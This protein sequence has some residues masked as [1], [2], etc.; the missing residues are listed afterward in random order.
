MTLQQELVF[1]PLGGVGEI[2]MNLSIY[3]IG[4][5][6]DRTWLAVDLGVS[7]AA[8][9]HLPGID[10]ILPDIRYLIEERRN[11]A[12]L[13][14]THAHEDH[15]GALLELWPRLKVPLYATPFTAALL[16]AKRLG[17]PGAPEIPVKIIPVGGRFT[18]G[19]FDIEFVTMAHSIPESNAL[20]IRTSGGTIL[21]TGDWKIDPTPILRDPT[22]E[23]KLRALGQ[24]GCLALVGDSTN[25]VREGRSP[26][27]TDVA[28]T[29]AELVKTAR[30][31]VAVTTFASNVARLRAVADAARAAEREVVVIGRAMERIVQIARETG[32][33]EGVQDFHPVEAYGYLP[34]NKVVA[35]CTGS[36]GESRAALSRIAE[37]QH[38]EVT[39]SRGDRVIYSARTIPGNEKAVGRV[40]NLLIEQGIEVITDRTHLV[41]VSGHP[42]RAELEEMF[43][44]VKPKIVIP[45]HG[46][47]LHLHEHAALARR[48]GVPEVVQCRNGDLVQLAPQVRI[49]DEV[50]AGRLYKDG[51]LLVEAEA[52][53]VADRRRLGFAGAVSVALAI[54]D[55][56]E[57]IDEPSLD[58]IGIPERDRDGG[59]IHEAVRNTV[60][61]TL[62]SLPRGRRRDPDAVAEAVRRAVRATI[63]QRWGKKPMCHV[64]VLEV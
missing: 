37:D 2:G 14:L 40:I 38:P 12:G 9:E 62:E 61:E 18:V 4:H 58:L 10:L 45:V 8:E 36:Q 39:F 46:E 56:G 35:L 41:H 25:A 5:E 48:C 60:I 6:H 43:G 21:H 55:R 7:F 50:P 57:L 64:H 27:E 22:D 34:P 1:A 24:E 53:T 31:R 11:L 33:L 32:Y 59:Q 17:E 3:G 16:E 47:A 26:S 20:I 52:R 54:T 28:K 51:I 13:V 49:I 44:W 15:F 42:R 23:K 30:G 19:P 29:I 63:A